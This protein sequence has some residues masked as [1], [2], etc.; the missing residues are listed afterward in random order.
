MG[1]AA[2]TFRK[3]RVAVPSEPMGL[4]PDPGRL[5]SVVGVDGAAIWLESEKGK[6]MRPPPIDSLLFSPIGPSSAILFPCLW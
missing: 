4:S 3:F 2:N 6:G 5:V 1:C